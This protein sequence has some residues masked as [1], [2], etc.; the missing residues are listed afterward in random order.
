VTNVGEAGTWLTVHEDLCSSRR[1]KV[2]F[3]VLLQGWEAR[4][5]AYIYNG[6]GSLRLRAHRSFLMKIMKKMQLLIVLIGTSTAMT[7][8]WSATIDGFSQ[9][10]LV[11]NIP[12]LAAQTDPNLINPWG[13][14]SSGGSPFWVSD[15]GGGASTLYNTAGVPQSLVVTVPGLSGNPGSPTGQIFNGSTNFNSDLFIF[16]TED[17]TVA[18][19]RGALGTTAETLLDN[20]GAGAVYK[21]LAIGTTAQGTYLY[22]A[23]FH[24][25]AIT[26]VP[27][28]GAPALSGTFTDPNLPSGYAPFNIQNLNGQLFVTYAKQDGAGHDDVRGAGNGFVDVYGLNGNF[29]SRFVSGGQLNSPWGLAIAPAEFG[30]LG[31]DVLVGNFG[32]GLI[33]V[34]NPAGGFVGT[35]ATPGGVALANDGLWGL[36]FGN[37]GNGGLANSLYVTA[38]LN[39]E[40]DGL[41]AQISAVPEPFTWLLMAGGLVTLA[42]RRRRLPASGRRGSRRGETNRIP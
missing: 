39:G 16:A 6:G 38:G 3:D 10:N 23:D 40:Q 20:S 32:D 29:V 42:A 15:N 4:G 27:G 21:G 12:G 14:S 13:I 2:M 9:V 25:N 24:N 41:F 8:L 11:S 35:L 37:G 30:G 17:G 1:C 22:L 36:K 28:T 19:W 34:F 26:A 31:G 18:G 7:S 33:N 5:A